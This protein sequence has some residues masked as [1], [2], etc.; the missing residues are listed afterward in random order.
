MRPSV[1]RNAV[2]PGVL[3]AE[4]LLEEGDLAVSAVDLGLKP[5][6]ARQRAS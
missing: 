4:F 3:D 1:G 5:N 2:H 6:M